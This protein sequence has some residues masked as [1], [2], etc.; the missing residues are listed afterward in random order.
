MSQGHYLWGFGYSVVVD[1]S[2]L[3]ALLLLGSAVSLHYMWNN[4]WFPKCISIQ[5]FSWSISICF[6]YV[7]YQFYICFLSI[8]YLYILI[9]VYMLFNLCLKILISQ[10]YLS[11]MFNLG[12]QKTRDYQEKIKQ[13][14]RPLVCLNYLL[15]SK[16]LTLKLD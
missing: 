5:I 7:V 3:R 15:I 13:L 10:K 4:F 8:H 2:I 9:Y 6:T 16:S 11:Y 14:P 12:L 1:L